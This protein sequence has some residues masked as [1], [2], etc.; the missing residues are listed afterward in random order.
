MY[1][2][3]N[4]ACFWGSIELSRIFVLELL[5][6]RVV[7]TAMLVVKYDGL[8]FLTYFIY[9]Y[10]VKSYIT[11]KKKKTILFYKIAVWEPD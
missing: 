6:A 8:S 1:A 4:K 2:R 9:L 11:L 10:T 7:T 5:V 3:V